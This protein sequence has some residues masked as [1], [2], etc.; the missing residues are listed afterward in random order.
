[1]KFIKKY[2]KEILIFLTSFIIYFLLGLVITYYLGTSKFWDVLFDMDCPRVLGDLT[3]RAYNHSRVSVHPLF[4]ILFQPLVRIINLSINDFSL[5]I[6]L[7]QSIITA[8]S[9]V[10]VYKI[11]EKI[12]KKQSL[13]NILIIKF[14]FKYAQIIFFLLI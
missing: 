9:A 11:L 10:I 2:K 13:I 3:S 6:P 14:I 4:V 7:I 12:T 1:M 5:T 8:T